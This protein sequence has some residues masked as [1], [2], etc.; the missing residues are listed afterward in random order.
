MVKWDGNHQTERV[1]IVRR[2]EILCLGRLLENRINWKQK[3]EEERT[4]V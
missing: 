4:T 2:Y 1:A 3:N